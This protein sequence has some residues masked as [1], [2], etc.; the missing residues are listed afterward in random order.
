MCL[1]TNKR[2]F[3]MNLIDTNKCSKYVAN[4]EDTLLHMLFDCDCV[5]PLFLWVFRCLPNQCG[6]IPSSNI[7]FKYFDFHL[8]FYHS[9]MEKT[10]RKFKDRGFEGNKLNIVINLIN[11]L[12]IFDL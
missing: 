5:K 12:N 2:L 4:V 3:A 10:K 8:Y 11:Y 6:F 7:R 9:H 1:A